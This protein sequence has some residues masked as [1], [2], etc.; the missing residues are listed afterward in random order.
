MRDGAGGRANR[1]RRGGLAQR[2]SPRQLGDRTASCARP[3][4]RRAVAMRGFTEL[5]HPRLISRRAKR[6][7][8][9]M[10]RWRLNTAAD[11]TALPYDA[12]GA[13]ARDALTRPEVA[14]PRRHPGAWHRADPCS[15]ASGMST[16]SCARAY[17]RLYGAV[18]AA[19]R[20]DSPSASGPSPSWNTTRSRLPRD[21]RADRLRQ[22][23]HWRQLPDFPRYGENI[24]AFS[25]RIRAAGGLGIVTSAWYPVPP[26]ELMPGILFTG[27]FTWNPD[28]PP[29][30]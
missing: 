30:A 21:R 12:H 25:R 16:T 2:G 9:S 15:S 7:L 19:T 24:H 10:A 4:R 14:R 3:D 20:P 11:T 29:E 8:E 17:A 26:E 6:W 22:H 5:Q 13:S 28:V 27:Q 1:L 23:Q 18:S